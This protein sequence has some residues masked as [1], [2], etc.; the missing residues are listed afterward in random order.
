MEHTIKDIRK[1]DH[2]ER[3]LDALQMQLQIADEEKIRRRNS[4]EKKL[5]QY[6]QWKEKIK[7]NGIKF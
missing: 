6:Q 1:R 3:E 5:Q 4:F 2:F 7:I